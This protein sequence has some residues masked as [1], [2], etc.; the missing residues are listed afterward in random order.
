M[1]TSGCSS[2]HALILAA[3]SA[4]GLTSAS[5]SGLREKGSVLWPG[6]ARW[7]VMVARSTVT[8]L[9]GSTTGSCMSVQVMGSS[10]S[11]GTSLPAPPLPAP[12]LA[13]SAAAACARATSSLRLLSSTRS[14][15][16]PACLYSEPQ[17]TWHRNVSCGSVRA[18]PADASRLANAPAPPSPAPAHALRSASRMPASGASTPALDTRCA[19]DTRSTTLAAGTTGSGGTLGG[20]RGSALRD[21][22]SVRRRASGPVVKWPITKGMSSSILDMCTCERVS[23][24]GAR[25]ARN[26]AQRSSPTTRSYMTADRRSTCCSSTLPSAGELPLRLRRPLSAPSARSFTATVNSVRAQP[27]VSNRR[28]MKAAAAGVSAASSA[29]SRP[30]SISLTTPLLALAGASSG[31]G[32]PNPV[33]PM[34]RCSSTDTGCHSLVSNAATAP[35]MRRGVSA[36]AASTTRTSAALLIT[37]AQHPTTASLTSGV[38]IRASAS[39]PTSTSSTSRTAEPRS[40]GAAGAHSSASSSPPAGCSAPM[41][42]MAHSRYT[43]GR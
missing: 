35:G 30:A 4:S 7:R 34:M 20:E 8:P 13:A 38:A 26:S 17:S 16:M 11:S 19:Q 1:P 29:A 6:V 28:F 2:L 31:C 21:S 33:A 10:K 23:A 24:A 22:R 36:S 43:Q 25:A 12:P 27:S 40:V 15:A 14:C 37:V 39:S 5:V 18:S 32:C 42:S 9:S 41:M 3:S